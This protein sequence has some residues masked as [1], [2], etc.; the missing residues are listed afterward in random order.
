MRV[1]KHVEDASLAMAAAELLPTSKE[2]PMKSA[3]DKSL[4]TRGLTR[5]LTNLRILRQ[6]QGISLSQLANLSGLR[7]DTITSLETGRVEPQPY[8]LR[9]L[10]RVLGVPALE[11]VS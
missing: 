11:L 3:K 10:A 6:R 8:H 5:G 4:K 2:R 1:K 9:M 7:R